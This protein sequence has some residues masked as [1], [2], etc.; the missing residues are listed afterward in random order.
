M[1]NTGIAHLKLKQLLALSNSIICSL[2]AIKG[3]I[4]DFF[5]GL[6]F[7]MKCIS[8][9]NHISFS[10]FSTFGLCLHAHHC[11]YLLFCR[12]YVVL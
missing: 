10:V 7:Q 11:V 1:C 9:S 4:K 3:L 5:H 12:M 8:L 6:V 2:A